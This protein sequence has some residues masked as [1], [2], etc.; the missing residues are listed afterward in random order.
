[1]Q[2]I[3]AALL[4]HYSLMNTSFCIVA[5]ISAVACCAH[6]FSNHANLSKAVQGCSRSR[7]HHNF[8]LSKQFHISPIVQKAAE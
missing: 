7:H 2:K 8:L 6:A 1:M 4:Q 3:K 5:I